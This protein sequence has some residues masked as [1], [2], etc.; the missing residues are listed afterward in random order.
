MSLGWSHRINI[1][2]WNLELRPIGRYIL[3][4]KTLMVQESG[5]PDEPWPLY[6]AFMGNWSLSVPS[7]APLDSARTNYVGTPHTQ[8]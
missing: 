2:W 3:N 5:A 4:F 1:P 6:H 7:Y 8:T